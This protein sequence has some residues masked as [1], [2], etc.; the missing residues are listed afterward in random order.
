[1]KNNMTYNHKETEVSTGPLRW[2]SCY[3]ESW[4]ELIVPDAFAHP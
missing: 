2:Q 4:N 1:M 3:Q